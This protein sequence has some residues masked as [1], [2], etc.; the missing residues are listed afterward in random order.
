[1]LCSLKLGP[2]Y[3][4]NPSVGAWGRGS[5]ERVRSLPRSFLHGLQKEQSQLKFPHFGDC[6]YYSVPPRA[7]QST[8]IVREDKGLPITSTHR[9]GREH[10]WDQHPAASELSMSW[11][12][13]APSFTCSSGETSQFPWLPF[14]SDSQKSPGFPQLHVWCFKIPDPC[15]SGVCAQG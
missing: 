5:R 1:M 8:G 13:S 6:K 3:L 15:D 10:S 7:P 9:A 4:A 14:I 12:S 2:N 11:R